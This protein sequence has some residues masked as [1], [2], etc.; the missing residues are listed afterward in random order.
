M[1]KQ[2]NTSTY[3]VKGVRAKSLGFGLGSILKQTV[4]CAT[5]KIGRDISKANIFLI[6]NSFYY[7][8]T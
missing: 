4:F 5:P 6:I 7:W 1:L 3:F 8:Q 2:P